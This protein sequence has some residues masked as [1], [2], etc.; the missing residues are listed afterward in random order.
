MRTEKKKQFSPSDW[1]EMNN[2][3]LRYYGRLM[4]ANNYIPLKNA[5]F[6]SYVIIFSVHFMLGKHKQH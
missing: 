2:H 1:I 6:N 5:I 3:E 4:Q